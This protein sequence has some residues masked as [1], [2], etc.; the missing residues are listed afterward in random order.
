VWK[1]IKDFCGYL[2][3]GIAGCGILAVIIAWI[4]TFISLTF[5]LAIWSANWLWGM[6]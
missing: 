2:V 5:G 3:A 1:K 4:V 6:I